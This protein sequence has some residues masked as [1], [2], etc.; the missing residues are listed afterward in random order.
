[1]SEILSLCDIIV[2][3]EE[4]LQMGLGLKS[5]N[6]ESRKAKDKLDLSAFSGMIDSRVETFPNIKI[7]ATTLRQISV[8]PGFFCGLLTICLRSAVRLRSAY[9]A[10]CSGVLNLGWAHGAWV[11]PSGIR[12]RPVGFARDASAR[13]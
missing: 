5:P 1:M 13:F 12:A 3:N 10:A 4:D 2:E 9:M 7:S 11:V 8:L 6:V